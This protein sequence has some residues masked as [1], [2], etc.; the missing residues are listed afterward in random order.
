MGAAIAALVAF[1][2]AVAWLTNQSIATSANAAAI[3]DT[4]DEV[5]EMRRSLRRIEKRLAAIG[6]KLRVPEPAE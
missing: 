3:S 1:A 4:Q 2:G 5:K 6:Q